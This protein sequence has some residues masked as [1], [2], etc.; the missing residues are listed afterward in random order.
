MHPLKLVEIKNPFGILQ[1]TTQIPRE[2]VGFFYF[3]KTCFGGTPYFSRTSHFTH[4][5]FPFWTFLHC[6]YSLSPQ[7]SGLCPLSPGNMTSCTIAFIKESY[8]DLA[9]TR[10]GKNSP[11][12]YFRKSTLTSVA[13]QGQYLSWPGH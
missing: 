9:Q 4:K 5:P 3:K 13:I 11:N 8:S 2:W 12:K 10:K 1:P 7:F 6:R